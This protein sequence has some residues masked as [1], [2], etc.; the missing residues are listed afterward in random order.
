MSTRQIHVFISHSWTYSG[1]YDTL[2]NWIFSN[3]WHYG[4][5]SLV[6]RDYSVPKDDPI[7]DA[8]SDR[9]LRDALY[10]KIAR[11]HVVVIP[12]GMYVN[13]KPLGAA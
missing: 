1:H 6:F 12:T 2:Y 13:H 11:S 5:A 8:H 4:Q 10:R 3:R 9:E 7:H